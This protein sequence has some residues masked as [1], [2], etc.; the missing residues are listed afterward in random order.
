MKPDVLGDFTE[1][2]F[3]DESFSLVILDPPHHTT[4]RMGTGMNIIRNCYGVLLPGW[5]EMLAKGFEEC[6]RVLRPY[7]V[8]IFKWCS[9]E[10]PLKRVLALTKHKP[11]VGHRTVKKNTTH[12]VTFIKL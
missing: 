1:M 5:E 11:L 3:A 10:I 4:K 9:Q 7:G 2:P 12:W 6:F 8:L